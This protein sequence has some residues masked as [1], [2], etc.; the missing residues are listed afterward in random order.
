MRSDP[1]KIFV[2]VCTTVMDALVLGKCG[3]LLWKVYGNVTWTR[4]GL[5]LMT[6]AITFTLMDIWS[7]VSLP[8]PSRASVTPA[9]NGL[10]GA[11]V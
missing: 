8:A 7:K 4:V 9:A 10:E 2:A 3:P 5:L 6:G 11:D 1:V